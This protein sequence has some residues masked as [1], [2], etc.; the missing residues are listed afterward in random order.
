MKRTMNT[1]RLPTGNPSKLQPM[2]SVIIPTKNSEATIEKCLQSIMMQTYKR[3]EV[4][5][6][7]NYS[8]DNTRQISKR[9]GAKIHL[10][11]PERSA[12][13]NFGAE[14]AIGKYIYR[15]DSDF[16]LQPNVIREAVE[17]CER[18]GYDAILIHN[19][20]DPTISLWSKVRKAE[21]DCYR[22]DDVNVAARFIRKKVFELI[23]GFDED[24]FAAE[25]YDLHNRLV[26]HGFRIGRISAEEIH[27]GEP[28]HLAEVVREYYY[29]G[30]NMSKFI[31]KNPKKAFRQLSP[32]RK[33]HLKGLLD[34]STDPVLAMGFV[35]YQL[36]RYTATTIGIALRPLIDARALARDGENL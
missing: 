34:S 3:I 32:L 11:G 27:I 9:Y 15:V 30:Q 16:V 26:R 29:Y 18:N 5:V 19:S 14:K 33:S 20:S 23:G 31:R 12:Q 25:D 17:N 24:L 4:I 1:R 36:V 22:N 13:I 28:K 7:D 21:R 2:V 8:Y 35:I 6:V 10:K